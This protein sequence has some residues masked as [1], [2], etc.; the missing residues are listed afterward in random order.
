MNYE[1]L[2]GPAGS[3]KTTEIRRRMAENPNY[4][5]LCATTGISA[6]NLNTQTINAVLGYF[7]TESLGDAYFTGRL[8]G[9]LQQLLDSGA[10]NLVIDE[11]SMM[12]GDQIDIITD[13]QE[14]VNSRD[15]NKDSGKEMGIVLTGDACQLP[16]ITSKEQKARG[17]KAKWFFE[18]RAWEFFAENVTRLDK[19]WRQEDPKFLEAINLIRSGKGEEAAD[20]LSEIVTFNYIADQQFEG[21]TILGRNRQV[22]TFNSMRL[23]R[24]PGKL[25]SLTNS[26]V[27]KPRGEWRY[28]PDVLSLKESAYVM[29][30]ANEPGSFRYANGDCGYVVRYDKENDELI[31]KL[32][33][34]GEEV[35]LSQ[36][37]RNNESRRAPADG[38]SVINPK[39][40]K[41]IHGSIKYYPVRLA[42]ASTVHKSQGLTLDNVQV[43]IRSGFF[44]SPHLT[45]VALSRARTPEGLKIVGTKDQLKERAVID[46]A[47]LPWV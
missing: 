28:I 16:P 8:T 33:R 37:T 3:G 46:P 34:T 14:D 30:L 40:G 36:I 47:V 27:G 26:R 23:Q 12:E 29:I 25:I 39:T 19:V 10:E 44:K 4:G 15:Y 18:S 2:T 24:Q 22:D 41:Y 9:R 38:P 20:L 45:Y 11:C 5:I 6:I 7:D 13:A 21:T 17:E 32:V 35:E 31:V 43:D 42:Y 1:F